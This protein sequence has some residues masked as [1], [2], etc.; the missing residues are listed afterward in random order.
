VELGV[1]ESAK[2]EAAAAAAAI[3]QPS[4]TDSTDGGT[5]VDDDAAMAEQ[6]QQLAAKLARLEA[7][8]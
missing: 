2:H 4:A 8:A 1:L 5:E 7:T 6:L 3:T